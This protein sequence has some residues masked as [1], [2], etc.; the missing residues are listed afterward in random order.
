MKTVL[1]VIVIL[2]TIAIVGGLVWYF[3]SKRSRKKIMGNVGEIV[4]G[5]LNVEDI[6]LDGPDFGD[7]RIADAINSIK[8]NLLTFVESTK[9]NVVTLSD[10]IDELSKGTDNN[11]EGNETIASDVTSAS[12][13]TAEQM[14]L[15]RD[16][17]SLIESNNQEIGRIETEMQEIKSILNKSVTNS[18]N[19]I[20]ILDGYESAIANMSAD[21]DN[22]IKIL[23]KFNEEIKRIG[24]VGDFIIGISGNLRL[25]ALNASVETARAGEAGKGFAVV[26]QEVNKISVKT[27][28][29]MESIN[30]IVKEV[31]ESSEQVNES[32]KH[33]SQTYKKS[34][35]TFR[36]VNDSFRSINDDSL[37]IQSKMNMITDKFE[38]MTNNTEESKNKAESLLSAS[39]AISENITNIAAVS[40]EV[41]AESNALSRN[42]EL[43][44]GMMNG[45]EK[46]LRQF[47]TAIVPVSKY[48]DRHLKFMV[49]SMY[50]N[51]FWYGVRRGALYAKKELQSIG[52]DLEFV[53]LEPNT[54]IGMTIHNSLERAVAQ[55]FS[56]I[57]FPGF[58]GNMD[59]EIDHA[60]ANGICIMPYNCDCK[61]EY[62]PITCLRP[63]PKEPGRI[64]AKAMEKALER[65]G[66]VAVLTGVEV[67]A[68][69]K[70][71]K[72]S[73]L[74][75][76]D[77]V[78]G[79]HVADV[80]EVGDDAE[81]VYNKTKEYLA[82]HED[83]DA[84]LITT[85]N[86]VACAKAIDDLHRTGS[87][88]VFSFDSNE[89]VF[90]YIKKGII[91]TTV[92]QD[93]F[94]QGHDPAIWLYNHIVDPMNYPIPDEFLPCRVTTVSNKN[95][96]NLIG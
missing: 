68:S 89:D 45:I 57:I 15:V 39:Q 46:L 48:K 6:Q 77:S 69:Y 5:R 17:L 1:I 75:Y 7:R 81:D 95:V 84:L 16:N 50:D 87:V 51:D 10:S 49:L 59:E 27:R 88:K 79:I 92:V 90:K 66:E 8:T 37:V 83:I 55:G 91:D 43:L 3:L 44:T 62:R 86:P 4:R 40:Q 13:R 41:A 21:L 42:T 14:E 71:R 12:M 52:S 56:G 82:E 18:K 60:L 72:E 74:D 31:I 23:D 29:G 30:K 38:T 53:P 22:I 28:E 67:V 19:G 93:S 54:D 47:D 96:E 9:V 24:E 11:R 32:I 73:F 85:G 20:E 78:P 76:M 26:A 61:P 65:K 25:L 35:E 2:E 63:D 64:A 34:T 36:H 33:C 80:I 94:G 58:L 70:E